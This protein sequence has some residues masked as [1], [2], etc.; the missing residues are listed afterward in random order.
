M[1][2]PACGVCLARA[3]A[4]SS[5]K[6]SKEIYIEAGVSQVKDP[7]CQL[8]SDEES[9]EQIDV[10]IPECRSKGTERPSADTVTN[11]MLRRY[12]Y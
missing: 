6:G 1:R 2:N 10:S 8:G 12:P 11:T 4:A 3:C 7:E 9:Y 5:S